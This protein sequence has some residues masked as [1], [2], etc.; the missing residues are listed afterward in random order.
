M[1]RFLRRM[2]FVYHYNS[3]ILQI[4]IYKWM[5]YFYK[6][7]KQTAWVVYITIKWL[8]ILLTQKW[9]QLFWCNQYYCQDITWTSN[10]G[11]VFFYKCA[12]NFCISKLLNGKIIFFS[13]C[14]LNCRRVTVLHIIVW[15][16]QQKRMNE[17]AKYY[18]RW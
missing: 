13:N 8:L 15:G 12:I 17:I 5:K 11:N 4:W 1:K 7:I 16:K 6:G 10:Q 18:Q 3:Q 9:Y 14:N 2:F